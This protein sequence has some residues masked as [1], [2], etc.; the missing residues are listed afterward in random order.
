[1]GQGQVA[2]CVSLSLMPESP[3]RLGG[4]G[5]GDS[6]SHPCV[7]SDKIPSTRLLC[8]S[9][10]DRSGGMYRGHPWGHGTPKT[11]HRLRA[12]GPPTPSCS[13][14]DAEVSSPRAVPTCPG[15]SPAV[16]D[17][18]HRKSHGTQNF[19]LGKRGLIPKGNSRDQSC[20]FQAGSG[21]HRG[22]FSRPHRRGTTRG[23]PRRGTAGSP[24]AGAVARPLLGCPGA[25]SVEAASEQERGRGSWE[26][27]PSPG[28]P[29]APTA[30]G[31]RGPAATAPAKYLPEWHRA[32]DQPPARP[33]PRGKA[34]QNTAQPSSGW[35][36][37]ALGGK[38]RLWVAKPSSR[39]QSP[40]LGDK[41]WI[42]VTS[43]GSV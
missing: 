13:P 10:G 32:M 38:S 1:M 25:V 4:R 6:C 20:T 23:S 18:P 9:W 27:A 26:L 31:G 36:I 14:R 39:W 2:P 12:G 43:L 21:G 19:P 42:C 24:A 29:G 16:G 11:S 3:Q 30:A 8:A 40:A 5:Q 28:S 37:L 22:H 7:G 33:A 35:Q 17:F 41:S 15:S 34:R